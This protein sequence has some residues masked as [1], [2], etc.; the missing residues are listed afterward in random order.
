MLTQAA[1]CGRGSCEEAWKRRALCGL[2]VRRMLANLT[3]A[4][5]SLLKRTGPRR[6][7]DG[8]RWPSLPWRWAQARKACLSAADGASQ[9]RVASARARHGCEKNGPR[10]G[11]D[12]FQTPDYLR[13]TS[14]SARPFHFISRPPARGA[15]PGPRPRCAALGRLAADANHRALA[16]QTG[17]YAAVPRADASGARNPLQPCCGAATR[18]A[19]ELALIEPALLVRHSGNVARPKQPSQLCG[20]ALW[21][22]YPSCG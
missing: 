7:G 4:T 21:L 9:A 15:P 8:P 22:S 12:S 1:E 5:S 13:Q 14:W 16:R 2:V 6:N 19:S 10:P 17:H 3:M 11:Q 18:I 20:P